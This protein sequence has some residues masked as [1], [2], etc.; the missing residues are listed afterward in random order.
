MLKAKKYHH[1]F[2]LVELIVVITILVILGTIG[3]LSVGDY[4]SLSRDA[5]RVSN[6]SALSKWLEVFFASNNTYPLPDSAIQITNNS[7]PFLYQ[8][9]AGNRVSSVAKVTWTNLFD[10]VDKTLFSYSTTADQKKYELLTFLEKPLSL[11]APV[12]T[13][14]MSTAYALVG[15][16]LNPITKWHEIWIL[17][18]NT[19]LI[20]VDRNGANIEISTSTG[21]YRAILNN[22][23]SIEWSGAKLMGLPFIQKLKKYDS[24][25]SG[26]W[27]ME[28]TFSGSLADLSGNGNI[29]TRVW[30]I[31]IGW[32]DW[33]FGKATY[34]ATSTGSAQYIH[35]PQWTGSNLLSQD[36]VTVSFWI[37]YQ[38]GNCSYCSFLNNFG[39]P[40]G[41]MAQRQATGSQI[42]MR[43]DTAASGTW[44]NQSS[45]FANVLNGDWHHL[46]YIMDKGIRRAYLNGNLLSS[47][48]YVPYSGF[49]T[50]NNITFFVGSLANFQTSL[51][52]IRIYN[53]VL[54]SSEIKNL[55]DKNST[56]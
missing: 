2:T 28:T 54:S 21:S 11:E 48:T 12:D 16:T 32:V 10:P 22:T 14:F 56:E 42:Y 4:T 31:T 13:L 19:T 20:P 15:T 41:Y 35:I 26:Y 49:T 38:G 33:K 44:S 47:S 24:S 1:W 37:K 50:R 51:D 46:I 29:G 25:L 43:I 5:Q 27:D 52:E 39:S 23:N 55:F 7:S 30:A 3:F 9:V 53:R 36:S 8:W 6:I 34:S 17:I 40:T 18:E 45:G